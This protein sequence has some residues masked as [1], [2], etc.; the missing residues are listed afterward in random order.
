MIVCIICNVSSSFLIS[1][2]L[3]LGPTKACRAICPLFFIW[4]V[5]IRYVGP[6]LDFGGPSL[7]I[8]DLTII[9]EIVYEHE[10]ISVKSLNTLRR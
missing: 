6:R 8:L 10:A 7:K 9:Q 4:H 3:T 5:F 1:F 2:A